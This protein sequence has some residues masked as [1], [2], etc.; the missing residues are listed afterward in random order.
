MKRS[1]GYLSPLPLVIAL[2]C[3]RP[4]PY[5]NFYH[6]TGALPTVWSQGDFET[7]KGPAQIYK[8]SSN[9]TQDNQAMF[10]N[11]YIEIGY[12]SFNGSASSYSE[13]D[14]RKQ[15]SLIGASIVLV[16]SSYTNTR[17]GSIPYTVQNP[18]QMIYS[19]STGTA[20]AYG[21]GGWATG[22]YSGT[23]T[24]Y[25]PGGTSTYSIP[26]SV[27]R[28]DFGATYWI[29]KTRIHFGAYYS[30]LP[31]Q[32]RTSLQRNQGVL[33]TLIIKRTPAWDAN[34]LPGDVI[35]RLNG[36][37]V[38]DARDFTNL[39]TGYAGQSI[40]LDIIRSGESKTISLHENI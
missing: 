24:T 19:N 33:I 2:G 5:S 18:G 30:D 36:R 17:T 15:S 37:D 21:S 23:T 16:K 13:S 22:T 39:I 12:S 38:A 29:R 40:T 8:Y 10:E 25:V 34:L 1:V 3:A 11:G 31:N 32:L 14:I 28:Y 26:Y 6:A 4:N 27:D 7:A 9:I 35:I 20:N